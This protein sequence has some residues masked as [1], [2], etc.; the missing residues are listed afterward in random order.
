MIVIEYVSIALAVM[1]V[2][3]RVV[4]LL[5]RSRKTVRKQAAA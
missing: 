5:P 2:A 1:A 4:M 3:T